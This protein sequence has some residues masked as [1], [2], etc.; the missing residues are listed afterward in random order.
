MKNH[1]KLPGKNSYDPVYGRRLYSRAILKEFRNCRE[2][3]NE[4]EMDNSGKKFFT[5]NL[6]KIRFKTFCKK[7]MDEFRARYKS[8]IDNRH[9]NDKIME[10]TMELDTI[11]AIKIL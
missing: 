4:M 8:S 9:L 5:A 7:L 6:I 3:L 1:L 2:V 10:K 11:I